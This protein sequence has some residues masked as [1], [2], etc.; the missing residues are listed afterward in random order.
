[1]LSDD[2]SYRHLSLTFQKEWGGLVYPSVDVVKILSMSEK[3]FKSTVI[4]TDYYKPQTLTTQDVITSELSDQVLFA[5][6]YHTTFP[7]SFIPR[8]SPRP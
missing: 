8:R 7:K 6:A 3:I 4:G 5:T 1:M 2:T